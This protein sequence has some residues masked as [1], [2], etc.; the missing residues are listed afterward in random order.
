VDHLAGPNLSRGWL[1]VTNGVHKTRRFRL[2]PSK[3]HFVFP[4]VSPRVRSITRTKAAVMNRT[5][6]RERVETAAKLR[7]ARLSRL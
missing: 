5:P 1:R 7:G 2:F 4:A 6:R 3:R